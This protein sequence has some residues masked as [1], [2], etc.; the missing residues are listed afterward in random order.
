MNRVVVGD[1]E[2][3]DGYLNHVDIWLS[4]VASSVSY[5]SAPSLV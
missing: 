1:E 3:R 5:F 2:G 4:A